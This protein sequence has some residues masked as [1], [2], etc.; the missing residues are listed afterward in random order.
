MTAISPIRYQGNKRSLIPLI[1]ENAP[2]VKDCSRFID[3]FGGSGTVCLNMPQ[4]FRVYNELSPQVF[5]IV[6][7]LSEQDP[8]KTLSQ[9]KRVVKHWA[10][11]NSSETSYDDFR[12]HV[13]KKRT[14]LLHYVAHRHSH[15]NM[16]RFNQQG[17]YNV[18]FGARGL[19]GKFDELEH[20][21]V[22]FHERMQGVHLT[23]LR[24]NDL[25][26]KVHN[27]LNSN[28]F[29]YFDP[30]Y[31]ASGA[32]QYGKWTERNER[33]LLSMLE[34][35]TRLGVPWMLSNVVEHRHFKND[36]LKRWLK[37]CATTVLYPNKT[38]A[39]ANGQ[40]GS[41]GTVEILAMNY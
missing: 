19:I 22:Q 3:A 34:H 36:L 4:P 31:L 20:E 2:S 28:T 13:Q 29:C 7:M 10:L 11:T 8:K 17:I 1:L 33:N 25:L 39:L 40:G 5:E 32:M 38:Y 24:Y 6:K 15:S 23:N 37:R 16:L 30:P 27:Q 9:I 26:G 21:L 41:H 35:L 12:V 14:P 18:P